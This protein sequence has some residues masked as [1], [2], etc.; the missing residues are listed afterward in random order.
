MAPTNTSATQPQPRQVTLEEFL[1]G[2]RIINGNLVYVDQHLVEAITK[3]KDAVGS[4]LKVDLTL[5]DEALAEA[6]EYSDAI[7]GVNPPGCVYPP[8]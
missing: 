5:V 8:N 2:Q 4:V 6:K 7:P 1:N 3:L